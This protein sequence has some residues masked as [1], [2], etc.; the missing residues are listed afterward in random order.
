MDIRKVYMVHCVF[1]MSLTFC[2]WE[3]GMTTQRALTLF[4]GAMPVQALHG[5]QCSV[6][7]LAWICDAPDSLMGV[8]DAASGSSSDAMAWELA[9]T[10]CDEQDGCKVADPPLQCASSLY[11]ITISLNR[12]I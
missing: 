4:D 9:G 8:V 1:F 12:I 3:Q 10:E 7:S 2:V 11:D 5:A 6:G